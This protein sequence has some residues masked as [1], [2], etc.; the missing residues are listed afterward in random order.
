MKYRNC[1]QCN[2]PFPLKNRRDNNRK[3]CSSACAKRAYTKR[4]M[5]WK[6]EHPDKDREYRRNR[7]NKNP[8]I[9]RDKVRKER[10][11]KIKLLGGKCIA[12]GA[13]NLNWLHI[14]YIP[15]TKEVPYRHPRHIN[16]IRNHIKD[17]RILCAN[18]H[19]EL[20]LT[21]KIEGTEIEQ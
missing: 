6:K 14:D 20:S 1:K 15:T 2:K 12:C 21:G 7:E 10:L 11:E 13:N 18:H 5:D 17:F 19:Y 4:I 16:Y 9:W 8:N 3:Y